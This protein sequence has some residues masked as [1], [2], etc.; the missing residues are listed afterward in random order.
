MSI[1]QY[2]DVAI[3]L[4]ITFLRMSCGVS[5]HGQ[6]QKGNPAEKSQWIFRSSPNQAIDYTR[7]YQM[8]FNSSI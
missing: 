5:R 7:C 6:F 1:T 4:L 2:D 3:A 8:F